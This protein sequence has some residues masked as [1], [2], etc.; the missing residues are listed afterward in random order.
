MDVPNEGAVQQRFRLDPEIVPGLALAFGISNESRDQ[1]QDVLFRVDVGEGVVVHRLL[2][3]D[4]IQNLDVVRFID[5]LA[6]FTLHG[7]INRVPMPVFYR[8]V[9]LAQLGAHFRRTALEHLA[10]FHQDRAFSVCLSRT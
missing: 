10:A 2:K 3:V 5:H 4:G 6:V 9:V 8:L 7:L 1:L